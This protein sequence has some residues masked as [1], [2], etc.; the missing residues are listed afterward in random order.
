MNLYRNWG[1][2]ALDLTVASGA[3]LVGGPT[4]LVAAVLI[5]LDSPG[6]PLFLQRRLG[7]GGE[8]FEIYKLRTMTAR[9]R[10]TAAEI[11]AGDPEVTRVGEILRRLKL[12]EVPQFFNVLRGEM[13]LIGP[14]PDVPEH[15]HGYSDVAR[16]R[17]QVRPGITGLAQTRGN[18]HLSWPERWEYDAEY[19]RTLSFES[20]LRIALKTILVILQ[21]ER[22]FLRRPA[23]KELS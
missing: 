4:L 6:S 5:R 19:V 15:L 7:R 18:I 17:L 14:R 13:S 3:L 10:V 23:M 21:G 20:D 1:K 16:V 12:D 9:P 2:R 11:F 22:R 8:T